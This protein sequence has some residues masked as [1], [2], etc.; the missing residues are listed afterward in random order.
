M[1]EIS[2]LSAPVVQILFSG[3]S[4]DYVI[5]DV[6]EDFF[7][8]TMGEYA[9]RLFGP[10][11]MRA[12]LVVGVFDSAAAYDQVSD[13]T[14]LF[15]L[16]M[17]RGENLPQSKPFGGFCVLQG[18]DERQGCLAFL[19]V[20]S[21]R[22]SEF[23]SLAGKVQSIVNELE[24]Y[25]QVVAV[26]LEGHLLGQATATEDGACP[27]RRADEHG[28]FFRNYFEI[29]VL[30]YFKIIG[31]Y[32]LENFAFGHPGRGFEQQLQDSDVPV[33]DRYL[34]GPRIE[35]IPNEHNGRIAPDR[36]CRGLASPQFG[37]VNNVVVQQGC[38]MHEFEYDG[39]PDVIVSLISA[40]PG[41]QDHQ[42]GPQPFASAA[43]Y[44]ASHNRD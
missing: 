16:N 20:V 1:I 26:S 34:Y 19:E 23:F 5:G 42:Q 37:M 33:S 15:C 18:I 14:Y 12:G 4:A 11:G 36:V 17:L 35:K 2:A 3:P 39:K 28:G 29:F 24:G 6:L 41:G 21:D 13:F 30:A 44:I 10:H 9:K 7:D 25:A 31:I 38:R 32:E 40:K 8:R 27:A 22:F 43:H